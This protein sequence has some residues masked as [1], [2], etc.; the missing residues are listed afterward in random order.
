M[1]KQDDRGFGHIEFILI[2]VIVAIIGFT[3][4]YVWH[5]KTNSEKTLNA[6][7]H[8]SSQTI[9]SSLKPG[10]DSSVQQDL[11]T[12]GNATSQGDKELNNADSALNDQSTLTDTS[13]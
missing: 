2:F 1:P 13:Q 8:S 3:G 10:V 4:W 11:N 12:A 7:D 9:E 5:A 6:D